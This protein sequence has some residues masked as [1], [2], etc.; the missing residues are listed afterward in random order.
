MTAEDLNQFDRLFLDQ[1]ELLDDCDCGLRLRVRPA[2]SVGFR[3]DVKVAGKLFEDVERIVPDPGVCIEVEFPHFAAYAVRS[4]SYWLSEKSRLPKGVYHEL[5][6]SHFLDYSSKV[7]FAAD[8][9]REG[10]LV[11]YSI[12]CMDHL[13]DVIAWDPPIVAYVEDDSDSN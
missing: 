12:S 11:H 3:E 8:V 1:I 5:T 7:S 10:R 9:P 4:E 6:D 2:R 13:I